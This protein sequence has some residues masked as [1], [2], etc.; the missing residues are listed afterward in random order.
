MKALLFSLVGSIFAAHSSKEYPFW[1]HL[2][3]EE[4]KQRYLGLRSTLS[5]KS[6]A[7]RIGYPTSDSQ[8]F[9]ADFDW[10]KEK[11]ECVHPVRDQGN[12]GSCWAQSASEVFSDRLCIQSKGKYNL[13][14][15]PQ[16]LVDC[17]VVTGFACAGGFIS[18]PFIYYA[19]VGAQE[20]SCYGA[21]TSGETGDRGEFCLI[22]KWTCPVF[23]TDL[24]S[25]KWLSS[26]DAIKEELYRRGPVNAGFMVYRDFPN[27]H[28]GVYEHKDEMI[29]GAHAVKIIGWGKDAKGEHWIVQNS[30]TEHWGENGFFRIRFGEAG[31]DANAVSINPKL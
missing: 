18:T 19:L 14:F 11:K 24:F 12:C 22:K 16:Q 10:R 3:E 7:P 4:W 26:P 1:S 30:W 29:L 8:D 6:S 5:Q 25:L 15:S 9:P 2:T 13:I 17:E 31:I 20:E 21:Y 23:K 28:T 27:Y